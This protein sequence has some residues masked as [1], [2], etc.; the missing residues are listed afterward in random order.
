[1][2]RQSAMEQLDDMNL[3]PEELAVDVLLSHTELKRALKESE[4]QDID[5]EQ[6]E[7]K[8]EEGHI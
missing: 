8:A 5:M 3:D 1:M 2:I 7:S 4:A 6:F